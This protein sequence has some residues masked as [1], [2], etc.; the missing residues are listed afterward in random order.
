MPPM[1]VGEQ[2]AASAA[3]ATSPSPD[4]ASLVVLSRFIGVSIRSLATHGSYATNR[5]NP[6]FP[7]AGEPTPGEG[8]SRGWRNGLLAVV[9]H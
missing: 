4:T 8:A 1:P 6:V 9:W 2:P 3:K 7:H 5:R